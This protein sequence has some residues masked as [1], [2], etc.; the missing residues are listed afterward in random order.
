MI[1]FRCE[2]PDFFLYDNGK[3]FDNKMIRKMLQAY[4]IKQAPTSP[5]D[6][7]ANPVERVN[8]ESSRSLKVLISMYVQADH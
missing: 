7:Q 2:M 3:E 5:N 8:P 6:A 4:G 1:L